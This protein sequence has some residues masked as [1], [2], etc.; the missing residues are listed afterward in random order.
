MTHVFIF[1][2][3]TECLPVCFYQMKSLRLSK[4]NLTIKKRFIVIIPLRIGSL[5]SVEHSFAPIASNPPRAICLSCCVLFLYAPTQNRLLASIK[6]LKQTCILLPN[7]V[8]VNFL[9][10]NLS[11]LFFLLSI[12]CLCYY[13]HIFMKSPENIEES[14]FIS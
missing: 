14:N 10:S 13:T 1:L 5:L 4:R 12:R 2:T 9:N 3:D 6:W 7:K 11:K 8:L